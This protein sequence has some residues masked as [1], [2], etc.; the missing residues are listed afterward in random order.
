MRVFCFL[1]LL[2]LISPAFLFS[3]ISFERTYGGDDWDCGY[4]V[5]QTADGG[6][7]ITGLTDSFGTGDND[8]YLIKTDPE[9]NVE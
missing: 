1:L 4:S 5:Q 7:V 8:V 9:G 2:S 3:Q 6:Y